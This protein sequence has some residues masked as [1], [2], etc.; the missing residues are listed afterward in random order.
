GAA[1]GFLDGVDDLTPLER[2]AVETLARDAAADVT[3]SLRY[4]PGRRAFAGRAAT[5]E[6]LR[7]LADEIVALEPQAEHYAPASR[8]ALHGLERALFEEAAAPGALAPGAAVALLEAGGERA[9][10]ELVAPEGG[11]APDAGGAAEGS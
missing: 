3:V 4:E 8:P 5:F 2:D 6:E 1:P 7:P 9:E 10:V 11:R